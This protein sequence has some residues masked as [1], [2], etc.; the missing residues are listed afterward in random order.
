M[1]SR[2]KWCAG[3]MPMNT[4]RSFAASLL[5][6]T[7]IQAKVVFNAPLLEPLTAAVE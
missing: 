1:A 4:L 2:R 3:P 5:L 6:P 7:E